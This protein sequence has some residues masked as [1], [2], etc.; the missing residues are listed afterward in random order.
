VSLIKEDDGKII[1]LNEIGGS[2][3]LNVNNVNKTSMQI[4]NIIKNK[5]L[6]PFPK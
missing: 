2:S 5:F 4:L 1:T 3:V 6:L